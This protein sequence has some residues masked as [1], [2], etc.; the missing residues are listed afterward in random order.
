MIAGAPSMD[1]LGALDSEIRS[2]TRCRGILARHPVNPPHRP[3]AVVPRPILSKPFAAPIMLVG[4][5][6]GL[7]EYDT[8][9]PFQGP[10]GQA[11][12]QLFMSTGVRPEQ[13]D[14][15]VYQTSAAK[16]FPGRKQ[17]AGRW[18]DRQ[19]GGPMLRN[20]SQFL[21]RQI[22]LVDP[23]V[24]VCLGGVATRA[25]RQLMGRRPQTLTHVLGTMEDWSER[26]VVFLSHTSGSSRLLNDDGNRRRQDE[27]L[28]RLGQ[29]IRA[30]RSLGRL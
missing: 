23:A 22:Q 21:S 1:P 16:C 15:V 30:L 6:P 9:L 19:P 18:E 20:C 3:E 25:V 10:A 17:N 2:C 14:A 26:R 24:I 5:A 27:G 11:I 12:R 4:Q 7:S 29:E 8:G 13:F 28:R